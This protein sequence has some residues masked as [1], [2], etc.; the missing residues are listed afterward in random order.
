MNIHKETAGEE[1]V[2]FRLDGDGTV[3]TVEQLQQELLA[4]LREHKRVQIDGEQIASLD[5][6]TIQTLCSA[7]RTAI[8]WNK[9][10]TFSSPLPP[11]L[12]DGIRM[13]G[14]ERHKGC[15]ICPDDECCLWT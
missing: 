4:G 5:F 3:E 9:Q 1:T 6:F 2:I 11:V 7:H 10:L 14:F 8:A 13:A 15:S 12:H